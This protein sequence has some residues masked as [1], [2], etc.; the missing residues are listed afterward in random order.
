MPE[1]RGVSAALRGSRAISDLIIDSWKTRPPQGVAGKSLRSFYPLGYDWKASIG[2]PGDFRPRGYCQTMGIK[3]QRGDA[4]D[5][6][7]W[8]AGAMKEDKWPAGIWGRAGLD[9]AGR[10]SLMVF[11]VFCMQCLSSTKRC[12]QGDRALGLAGVSVRVHDG[13]GVG[14]GVCGVSGRDAGDAAGTRGIGSDSRTAGCAGSVLGPASPAGSRSSR[15]CAP[16]NCLR[17]C[18]NQ[19]N[20]GH[21]TAFGGFDDFHGELSLPC[22]R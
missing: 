2:V 5:S 8:V 18:R 12:A 20:R 4:E 16:W 14:G 15:S 11:V 10:V 17:I 21:I 7:D 6:T 13:P 22:R 1:V 3:V 19:D 9:A